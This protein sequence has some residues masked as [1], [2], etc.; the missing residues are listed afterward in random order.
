MAGGRRC[1]SDGPSSR[2]DWSRRARLFLQRET[3]EALD[4]KVL[5]ADTEGDE[6]R[7]AIL[8]RLA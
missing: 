4:D 7:F 6:P 2:G 5:D 3:M 1:V 8:E